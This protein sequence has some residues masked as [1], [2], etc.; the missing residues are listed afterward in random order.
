MIDT[1]KSQSKIYYAQKLTFF[2]IVMDKNKNTLVEELLTLLLAGLTKRLAHH[3]LKSLAMHSKTSLLISSSACS[4]S[5]L[6]KEISIPPFWMLLNLLK[7]ERNSLSITLQ[8]T[9]LPISRPLTRVLHSTETL[10]N[11]HLPTV[12]MPTEL[13]SSPGLKNKLSQLLLNSQTTTLNQSLDNK[14]QLSCFSMKVTTT[15]SLNKLLK[16][17]RDKSYLFILACLMVSKPDLLNSLES[18]NKIFHALD[19]STQLMA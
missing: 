14:S 16:N 12:V 13:L 2:F 11:P 7:L 5:V 10:M 18:Q 6:L 9:A 17:L 4:I 19:F 8:L 1:I 15:Q 3:Q